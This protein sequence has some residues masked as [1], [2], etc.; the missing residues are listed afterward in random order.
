MIIILIIII[1]RY[2]N[3]CQTINWLFRCH[4]KAMTWDLYPKKQKKTMTWD[5]ISAA[6][7]T[8]AQ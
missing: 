4:L 1:I 5:N 7:W 6:I 2:E 8:M 3:R